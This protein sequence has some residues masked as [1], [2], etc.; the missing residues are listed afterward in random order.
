MIKTTKGSSGAIR[1]AQ[2]TISAALNVLEDCSQ[3]A[4]ALGDIDVMTVAD[5]IGQLHEIIITEA[6]MFETQKAEINML[7][8]EY[9]KERQELYVRHQYQQGKATQIRF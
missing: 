9:H 6:A 4:S 5:E 8:E 2:K 3:E 7:L 1:V